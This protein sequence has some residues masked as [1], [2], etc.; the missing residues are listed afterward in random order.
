MER[1]LKQKF[2]NHKFSFEVPC[3]QFRLVK[4]SFN[5]KSAL[6]H[7]T[8]PLATSTSLRPHRSLVNFNAV[9]PNFFKYEKF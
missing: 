3:L 6:A 9:D 8:P 7:P 1:K 5:F 4:T 2:W